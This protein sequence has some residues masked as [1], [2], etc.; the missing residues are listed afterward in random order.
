MR[1]GASSSRI[2]PSWSSCSGAT[3]S[4]LEV[5]HDLLRHEIDLLRI[6]RDGAQHEVLKPRLPKVLDAIVDP[7]DAADHVT[8]LQVVVGPVRSHGA[9]ERGFRLRDGLLVAR[10]I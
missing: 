8:F 4:L 3:P 5:L 1:A 10:R 7:V 2:A 9:Q 6:V